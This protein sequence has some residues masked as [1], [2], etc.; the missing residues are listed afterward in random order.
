MNFRLI[1]G[2]LGLLFIVLSIILLLMAGGFFGIERWLGHHVDPQARTALI[3]SGSI[4]LALGGAAWLFTRSRRTGALS[5]RMKTPEAFAQVGRRDAL[6]LVGVS[7]VLGAALAALPY[8][9]WAHFS[10]AAGVD[11]PFYQYVNCYFEAMSGFTTT[12]ATVLTDIEAVP[13]GLLLWRALTQWLGGLGIVVLFVAVLPAIGSSARKMFRAEVSGV[14]KEGLVPQIRHTARML[15]YIYLAL[16]IAQ[17]LLL[18]VAGMDWFDSI[19]HTM[20]TLATGGFSTK[21]ASIAAYHSWTIELII[22]IFMILGGV[23]FALYYQA[24][25]GRF[26]LVLQDSELR[27]YLTLLTITSLIVAALVFGK[28]MPMFDGETVAGTAANSL[29]HAAFD[30]I[31]LATTTGFATAEY[32]AWHPLARTLIFLLAFV[33]G[34]A[35]S[36]AGGVKVIRLLIIFKMLHVEIE[37]AFRPNVIRPIRVGETLISQELCLSTLAFAA[38]FLLL[39]TAC[40]TALM[41]FESHKGI[42]MASAVTGALACMSTIGPAL[43]ML[44]GTENY[45]WL[46]AESKWVLCGAMLVGRLEVFTV[47]VLLTPRFWRGR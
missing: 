46:S 37:R 23:N 21:N 32:D 36:T 24:I 2:Q 27:L 19:C 45:G 31:S 40:A 25:R 34:S 3:L 47:L 20:T 42:D 5:I 15:W 22:I 43:G 18:R 13:R 30:V 7:W 39:L 10:E 4:G 9:F 8:Y 17:V 14:T 16:T 29:R 6:L 33:G 44:G 26:K 1:I 28:P 35:G 38:G 12:G 41:G 11:H